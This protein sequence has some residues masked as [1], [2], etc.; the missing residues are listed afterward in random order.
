MKHHEVIGT[1]ERIIFPD[2]ADNPIPVK[3]DTGADSSAIWASSIS[4]HK[5]VLSFVFFAPESAHYNGVPHTTTD[6][7]MVKVKNSFGVQEYRYRISLRMKINGEEYTSLFTLADRSKNRF[8]V[9]LGKRF[10]AGNFVVDVTR[11]NVLHQFDESNVSPDVVVLTSRIDTPTREFFADVAKQSELRVRLQKYHTLEYVIDEVTGP[12]ISLPGGTDIAAASTVYFKAHTLYPEHAGAVACYLQYRHVN[13][14]DR[15]VSSFISRSKLSE[16]FILATASLPVP[17][18]RIFSAGLAD[19]SYGDLVAHFHSESIVLKDAFGDRGRN[20]FVVTD[21]ASFAEAATRLA[22]C[23]TVVAQRYVENDGFLRVLV[24]A[25]GIAQVVW[26]ASTTHV[27]DPLRNHLNKPRGSSNA[28][29]MAVDAVDPEALALAQR[30]ALVLDRTVAGVDLVQDAQTK[31][32]Y[33]LEVNYNPEMVG[34]VNTAQKATAIAKLL[35]E[36]ER[37]K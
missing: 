3:V 9:L 33:V 26:R 37:S 10:L 36:L 20:N 23:E 35:K 4:E 7:Q 29:E 25:S 22:D 17:S 6:Y 30:A 16:L 21:R 31:K 11:S 27:S 2:I 14:F 28:T 18:T 1:T 34:G 24:I 19:T 13:F 8:P 5:G 32:W 15:N 12:R